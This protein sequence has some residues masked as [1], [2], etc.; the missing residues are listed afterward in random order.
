MNISAD[1]LN[2]LLLE[3]FR[4]GGSDEYEADIVADHLI[5]ANLRGHDS[6]GVMMVRWYMEWVKAGHLKPN[7]P[8]RKVKDKDAFL[9]FDGG[10][11]YGQRTAWEALKAGITR[12]RKTGMATVTLKDSGHIGRLGTYGEQ[13]VAA[14]LVSL[15]FANAH[16]FPLVV[17]PVGGQKPLFMTNPVCFAMPGTEKSTPIIMDYATSSMAYGKAEVYMNKGI[18]AP[19]NS[20]ID[21]EG[22]PTSDPRVLFQKPY[23]SLLPFGGHKGYGLM[24]FCELLG[25][26][27]SG[28]GSVNTYREE[29]T[30]TVNNL[31]SI[32]IDPLRLMEQTRLQELVDGLVNYIKACPPV[33][34]KQPVLM[35]GEIE[36]VTLVERQAR[37]IP[38]DEKTWAAILKACD[39]VGFSKQD[40][41]GIIQ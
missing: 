6:H 29:S 1:N 36:R 38:L 22:R 27:L 8:A 15:H 2:A 16:D 7:T 41:Q 24:V 35:P 30:G 5:Q 34:A 37:G 20:I 17:A 21:H 39:T 12:C 4:R 10:R 26:C 25:G 23:G 40:A 19:L 3:I 9:A 28:G 18:A 13:A 14:G 31:F 32:L 11:G 33:N